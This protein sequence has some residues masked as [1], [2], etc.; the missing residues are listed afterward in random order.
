MREGCGKRKWNA[1]NNERG[2]VGGY[3]CGKRMLCEDYKKEKDAIK[4]QE[5]KKE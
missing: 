4:K 3:I 2:K 5:V 1:S